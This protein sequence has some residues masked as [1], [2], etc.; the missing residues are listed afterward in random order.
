MSDHGANQSK[1]QPLG[2]VM[3]R[4][5]LLGVW[6]AL[7]LL[8]VIT[9]SAVS[10]DL[11]PRLNLLVAMAIAT[12][13]ATLVVLFFMHLLYD[14]RFYLLIFLGALIFVFMFVSLV[15]LDSTAY[16]GDLIR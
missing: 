15:L 8:T 1:R 5:A 3:S 11:G 13:K 12:A 9:V 6:L 4:K 7:M 14:R 10:V 16:Q 2:H